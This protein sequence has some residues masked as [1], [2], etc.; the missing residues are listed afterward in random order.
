VQLRQSKPSTN[1]QSGSA[2]GGRYPDPALASSFVEV[3]NG[4][5]VLGCKLFP[6]SGLN[7]WEAME[8]AAGAPH[9]AGSQLPA[10]LTGPALVRQVLD[11]AAQSGFTVIRAW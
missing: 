1:G 8:A 3:K 9:L 4:E 7:Q 6:I 11:T 5:F 10:R 2:S